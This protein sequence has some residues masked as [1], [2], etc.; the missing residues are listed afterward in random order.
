MLWD[1]DAERRFFEEC[2][3]ER[4]V[5]PDKLFYRTKDGRYVAYW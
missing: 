4:K 5:S 2:L 1:K 3:D